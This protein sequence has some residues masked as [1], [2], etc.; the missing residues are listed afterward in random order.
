[1][2]CPVCRSEL[3]R[4]LLSHPKASEQAR[5]YKRSIAGR[6]RSYAVKW[7]HS[8]RCLEHDRPYPLR[9]QPH[10]LPAY[11][12]RA[13]RAVLLARSAPPRRRVHPAHRGHR[14]R[15]QHPGRGRRDPRGMEWLGLDYDEG[16][17]YQTQRMDRYRQVAEDLVAPAR[18]TTPARPRTTRGDAR[19]RAMAANEKPRYNGA[20][21]DANAAGSRRS[22]PGDPLPQSAGRPVV[23]DDKVK[24]ASRSATA[25]STTSSSCAP[26]AIRPT[27]SPSS[28]TTST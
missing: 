6:A 28:S 7:P 25:S 16:P 19:R 12:R 15:A 3:A 23:F 21:R 26:T 9:P 13:H 24:G 4:M 8:A 27:T 2:L 11:R 1:M 22:E 14:P 10:R 20:C 17:F 18:P 5:T